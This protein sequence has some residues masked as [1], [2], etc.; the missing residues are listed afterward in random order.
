MRDDPEPLAYAT[1][2][3]DG[4][5]EVM[6]E[7]E[8]AIDRCEPLRKIRR[9]F[10]NPTQMASYLR[11]SLGRRFSDETAGTSC[12]NCG[13][14]TDQLVDLAWTGRLGAI[15]SFRLSSDEPFDVAT[16]HALCE[17]CLER[18]MEENEWPVRVRRASMIAGPILMVAFF[19][20]MS[21]RKQL[22]DGFWWIAVPL[23]LGQLALS[24]AAQLAFKIAQRRVPEPLRR[25]LPRWV[26]FS[27][28]EDVRSPALAAEEA[29]EDAR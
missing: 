19:A 12:V 8:A 20:A 26:R 14:P 28:W 24:A 3:A 25:A 18:W 2:D 21:F 7:A 6:P 16:T 11:R 4:L 29:A 22:S 15:F 17:R 23:L 5:P 9:H 27:H 1:P 13:R 10:R